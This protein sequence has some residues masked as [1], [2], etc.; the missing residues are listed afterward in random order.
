MADAN[1]RPSKLLFVVSND[2]GELASSLYFALGQSFSV[3]LALPPR[4]FAP[5]G[6]F[7]SYPTHQYSRV[8]DLLSIA[9]RERP[10]VVL[11]F[12]GYLLGVNG[13]FKIDELRTLLSQLRAGGYRIA[14]TDPFLGLMNRIDTSTFN[15]RHPMKA[16]LTDHFN[17]VSQAM[18]GIVHLYPADLKTSA[19]H[20][21][22]SFFNRHIITTPEQREATEKQLFSSEPY[23]PGKRRWM[24][25]LSMEDYGLQISLRGRQAFDQLLI[26]RLTETAAAGRQPLLVAPTF[27]IDSIKQ[28]AAAIDGCI[29]IAFCQHDLYQAMAL[30]AEYLFYWN[31]FSHSVLG[32][33][34]N[35]LP[36]IFFDHG[37]VAQSIPPL[38][39]LGLQIYYDNAPIPLYP[40]DAALTP[41]SLAELAAAQKSPLAAV[42]ARLQLLPSPAQVIERILSA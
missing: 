17:S 12:S 22:Q 40:Q 26:R 21:G 23:R 39:L 16:W 36:V 28:Q 8:D 18:S 27:C 10:D 41:A 5:Q 37:H 19:T 35:G 7:M 38:Y 20:P 32:R 9:Q 34:A 29:L 15:D 30:E 14:T 13:I 4:L 2:F 6:R 42:I 11:L 3:V 25:V 31:I 33:V 1:T 24:F